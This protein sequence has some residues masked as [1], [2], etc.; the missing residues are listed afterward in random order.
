MDV[1]TESEHEHELQQ[2]NNKNSEVNQEIYGNAFN[3][4][5]SDIDI[6]I[7]E[8]NPDEKS[9]EPTPE[10]DIS[11]TD[12]KSRFKNAKEYFRSLEELQHIP[13]K[14][15][16][17]L[18]ECELM[19]NKEVS[20]S[21]ESTKEIPTKRLRK[22]VKSNSLPS[23]EFEKAW[24][25]LQLAKDDEN[26]NEGKF[27]KISEKFNV[28]D[29]FNDVVGEGRLSRQGSFKGIP[30]KKAV[31][32][33][34][35][36]MEN[37]SNSRLSSYEIAMSQLTDFAKENNIKNVQ[38]HC[39]EYPYLP[40]TEPSKYHSRC[41]TKASGL[42]SRRELLNNKQRRNSVPDLRMNAKFIANL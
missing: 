20:E 31:L 36:S 26:E 7:I 5:I 15:Q 18:N 3:S 42:V 23:S 10:Q 1:N 35:K 11:T 19:L 2:S 14:K 12:Y 38:T 8:N 16:E 28:D 32:E 4:F 27:L 29:L 6:E 9:S 33:T 13:E 24:S 41:D 21:P 25:Q 30:H 37:I 17:K 40:T 22:K 34:F 39:T